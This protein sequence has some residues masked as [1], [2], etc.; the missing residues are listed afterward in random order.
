MLTFI[1]NFT[2]NTNKLNTNNLKYNI[3]LNRCLFQ[4]LFQF[5]HGQGITLILFFILNRYI[6]NLSLYLLALI[7]SILILHFYL[8]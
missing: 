7:G 3:Y 6:I 1:N 2:L 8:F 4:L 5:I